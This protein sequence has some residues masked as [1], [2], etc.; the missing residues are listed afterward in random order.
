MSRG[1]IL[2]KL[3]VVL[4]TCF[5]AGYAPFAPGTAGAAVGLVPVYVLAPWPA[6]YCGAAGLLVCVGIAASGVAAASCKE[7]DSHR[8]V[9]DEAA[10][11]MLTF[12]GIPLAWPVVLTGFLL[13]RALDIVKPFPAGRAQRLPG[14]WGIMLDD[15]VA[16]V[17]ANLFLRAGMYFL[18][19]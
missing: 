14:G 11:I 3:A 10:S 19:T 7:K 18:C 17:Y 12:A 16:G 5:G 8:I 2:K 13:N 9:I 1:G 15:V 6:G 4:A